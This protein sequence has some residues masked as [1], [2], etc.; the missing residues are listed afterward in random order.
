MKSDQDIFLI[1]QA[2]SKKPG[3]SNVQIDLQSKLASIV[4]DSSIT[5]P[6]FIV[7]HIHGL[8]GGWTA[9]QNMEAQIFHV[10]GLNCGNCVKKIESSVE[11]VTVNL[12]QAKAYC[13]AKDSKNV[14]KSIQNLGFKAF[15]LGPYQGR[16]VVKVSFCA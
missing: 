2:L 7:D 10:Q 13:V 16:V 15:P 1:N 14:E 6:D 11:N 9:S 8:N 4:Y 5:A 3:L 12:P